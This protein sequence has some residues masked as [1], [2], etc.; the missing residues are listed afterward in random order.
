MNGRLDESERDDQGADEPPPSGR[1]ARWTVCIDCRYLRERPSG[2]GALVQALVD[3]VPALAPELHF[4]LLCHPRAPR[5]L[6]SAPNV[7]EVTVPWEANGPATL[8]ALPRLVDLRKVALFHATFNI[9][10]VGLPMPSVVTVHDLMW[11][12][13]P[14]W[15]R[16]RGL[17]GYA[18]TAFYRI[19]IQ[20]ALRRAARIVT[21]SEATRRD[22]AETSAAAG[23]RAEVIRP[24]VPRWLDR[25][26]GDGERLAAEARRELGLGAGER[27]VLVVGQ[28]APYKNH[29]TALLAFAR[30]FERDVDVRIVFVHRLGD[31][32][33]ELGRL[34]AEL[35]IASR[36]TFLPGVG[37][38]KLAGLYSGALALLHPSLYEGYGLPVVEAMACGCPVVGAAVA[39]IPEVAGDAA[40]LAP[41]TDVD[42]LAHALRRIATDEGLSRALREAGLRRAAEQ[43]WHSFAAAHVEVYRRLVDA[44]APRDVQS[45]AE[46]RRL[47]RTGQ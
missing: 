25:Y 8:L 15:A 22:V 19:G 1:R 4:L 37:D 9:L 43:S 2:V 30:A 38:A 40:L 11:L 16:S 13:T 45:P 44:S 14:E 31:G 3:L 23:E 46:P 28:H 32:A 36:V 33:G 17:W 12:R 10:P 21:P 6:S 26:R 5:P 27:Y 24:G 7:S 41:P 18:E 29:R 20:H 47:A 42:G 39:S 34:A 35:G